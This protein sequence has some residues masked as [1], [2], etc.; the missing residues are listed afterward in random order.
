MYLYKGRIFPNKGRILA[1]VS[2]YFLRILSVFCTSGFKGC[3]VQ[4]GPSIT[5]INPGLHQLP[6]KTAWACRQIDLAHHLL[7]VPGYT[8]QVVG[9]DGSKGQG[10]SSLEAMEL[11]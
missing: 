3:L 6:S 2:T 11:L 1:Y 9:G 10:G 4:F 7:G 8:W 5:W